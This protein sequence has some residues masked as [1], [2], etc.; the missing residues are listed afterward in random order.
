VNFHFHHRICLSG[1]LI[2]A[3]AVGSLKEAEG[4]QFFSGHHL[5]SVRVVEKSERGE[6]SFAES[7]VGVLGEDDVFLIN[8]VGLDWVS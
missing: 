4:N 3:R 8:F 1:T 7:G 5:S 2:I 6:K